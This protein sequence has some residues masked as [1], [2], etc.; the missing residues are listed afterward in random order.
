MN[1]CECGH[2]EEEHFWDVE[3]KCY[4]GPCAA[5]SQCEAYEFGHEEPEDDD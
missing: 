3:E 2:E 4:S 5:C 1:I